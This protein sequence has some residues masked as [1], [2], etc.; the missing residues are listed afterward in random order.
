MQK[1]FLRF[2]VAAIA[3]AAVFLIGSTHFG[4]SLLNPVAHLGGDR[5][6]AQIISTDGIGDKVYEALPD[7]PREDQYVSK[8]T[9]QVAANNTL[10]A[11]LIRYHLYVKGRPPFYRLDWKLT[12]AD[13]LG[14]N[15][16]LNDI[17]YPGRAQL[18]KN[19]LEGD[20]AAIRQL[21]V[22]QRNALVQAL[23]DAFSAQSARS[24][25]PVPK[26]VIDL[27]KGAR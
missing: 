25:R 18:N 11:R 22:A 6:I 26:P 17:D 15:G 9:G 27:P 12:L 16:V 14:V 10:V 1:R 3:T 19:P 23:V 13:Y 2:S 4:P 7:L 5:A 24:P 8:E 21:N 20:V